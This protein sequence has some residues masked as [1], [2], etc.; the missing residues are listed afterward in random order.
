[1]L[2]LPESVEQPLLVHGDCLD[3][4]ARL[5]AESVDVV[6]T[7]PPAAVS[8][9]GAEW[10]GFTGYAPRTRA[11]RNVERMLVGVAS[12]DAAI[13][14]LAAALKAARAA[15]KGAEGEA[16]RTAAAVT[17]ALASALAAAR[18][19]L[20]AEVGD[21]AD[22]AGLEPWAVGFVAFM[23]DVWSEVDRVLKPGG[24]VCA[25]ALPKTADLAGLA[26]RATGWEIFDS[27]LHLFGEGMSKAGD[28]GKKIDRI[29]GAERE[30]VGKA[31]Q[32]ASAGMQNI[33]ESTEAERWTDW[34]S[35]LAP[36]HEQWL[37]ARKP[38]RLTYA[39]QVLTHGCGA[40]N[41]G[42][43]RVPRGEEGLPPVVQGKRGGG[44]GWGPDE[45][46]LSQPQPGGSLPK[47][48]VLTE[49]GPA[50]PVAELDRQSGATLSRGGSRGAGGQH[51][52]Y[53]PIGAQPDVEPGFGDTGGASRYFTRFRYEAKNSDRRAGMR[54][55]I[56]NEHP[57]PKSVELMRWLVALLAAKAEHTGGLPA[58]VLDPFAGS[59]TTGVACVAERV[60]FIGIERDADSFEVGRARVLAAI[61][62][63]EAAAEANEAAPAGGQLALL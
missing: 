45:K 46:R 26:L 10:D 63:P 4:L 60:R 18:A 11:G 31:K 27:L 50:C 56:R 47:N 5:P 28:L 14:S 15:G 20:A 36:G 51:G 33:G 38:T 44:I 41:T 19:A 13:K 42:A 32:G 24:I 23:A 37:L 43:C 7:D 39:E 12:S 6:I 22:F 48:V 25:W 54:S 52:R 59:F 34:S 58:V 30:V 49:G 17:R 9:M 40:M 21:L 1:M 53:S 3:V 55:D 16:K 57:T 62:S 61:G 35:Q 29:L 2:S 8:F